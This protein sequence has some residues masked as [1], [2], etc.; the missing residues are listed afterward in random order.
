MA[1]SRVEPL[2][3]PAWFRRPNFSQASLI[4]FLVGAA[5]IIAMVTVPRLINVLETDPQQ[6]ALKS[7]LLLSTMTASTA[8]MAYVGVD[9]LS[10]GAIVQWRSPV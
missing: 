1:A 5:L 10:A 3:D 6:A 9:L 8:M 2:L 4:N 7:D